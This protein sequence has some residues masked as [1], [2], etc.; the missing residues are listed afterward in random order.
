MKDDLFYLIHIAECIAKVKEYVT[1]GYEEFMESTLIQDAVMR[2]LQ[3]LGESTRR[4]SDETKAHGKEIDWRAIIGLRNVMVHD[5]LGITLDRV[6][7]IIENDLPILEH[8]VQAILE[9]LG[10]E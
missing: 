4:L 8:Q 9:E 10:Q 2:N 3:I 7:E 6:W 5:Y 1:P